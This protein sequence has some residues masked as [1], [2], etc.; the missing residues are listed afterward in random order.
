MSL[1]NDTR[2]NVP[3]FIIKDVLVSIV[4][5]KQRKKQTNKRNATKISIKRSKKKR[6]H[7]HKIE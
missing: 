3:R 6:L 5:T 1:N 4:M 2:K 7:T